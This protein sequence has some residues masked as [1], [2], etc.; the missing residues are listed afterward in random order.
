MW[1][2]E[3]VKIGS[4]TGLIYSENHHSPLTIHHSLFTTHRSRLNNAYRPNISIWFYPGSI[5]LWGRDVA[6]PDNH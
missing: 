3:D 1:R 2:Y 4:K 6:T 5:P